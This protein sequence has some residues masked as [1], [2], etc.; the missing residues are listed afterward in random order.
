MKAGTV[1]ELGP[2]RF[3]A[4][5]PR[6]IDPARGRV[7]VYSTRQEAQD[8]VNA[9]IE[10]HR[11]GQLRSQRGTTL[12]AFLAGFLD[13]RELSGVR[14]IAR[15]RR[16]A[17]RHIEDAAFIDLPLTAIRRSAVKD[18]FDRLQRKKAKRSG[19]LLRAETVRN[20][21]NLLRVCF[22]DALERE[23]IETNPA[24]DLR[25]NRATLATTTEP[26]TY[27]EPDEQTAFLAA[28]PKAERRFHAFATGTGLRPG[29]Q[30][31]LLRSDV[32]VDGED[33]HV[34]V[35]FGSPK[36]PTKTG[37]VRR[38][39]LFGVALEAATE[40]ENALGVRCTPGQVFWPAADGSYRPE[41]VPGEWSD[42]LAAA[43]IKRPVRPYDLRHT[44][45]SS[46]VAGRWG[47]RW[48]L[49][50]VKEVLGHSDIKMTQRYAHLG[51]T[52]LRT[53]VRETQAALTGPRLV[54]KAPQVSETAGDQQS[55]V[56]R[57]SPV[58]VRK[59]APRKTGRTRTPA[60]MSSS[61]VTRMASAMA[62]LR[63]RSMRS[64]TTSESTPFCCPCWF[65]KPSRS[66]TFGRYASA[67]CWGVGPVAVPSYQ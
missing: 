33:P 36:K 47:R 58:Q 44:C 24:R 32:K 14:N 52:A 9:T 27:L 57:R 38:V 28:M 51:A 56:N 31:A 20:V 4:R 62:W 7:G 6:S 65:T 18:W 3:A 34:V 22:Q 23:L 25:L 66:F 16:A 53:A 13:R 35:R 48:T 15:D 39:P 55:F 45:A 50:E 59:L 10:M 26:W 11:S 64:V 49:E 46:L 5:L 60:R 41:G 29:E 8:V 67:R 17:K 54:Q 43:G 19:E 40:Q 61:P 12:R 30:K 42:W 63:E 37:K 2:G 21:F 1:E